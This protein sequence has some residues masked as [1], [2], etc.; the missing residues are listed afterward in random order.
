CMVGTVPT[1]TETRGSVMTKDT[2]APRSAALG[3]GRTER[4]GDA[5]SADAVAAS[6]YTTSAS[7]S[8]CSRCAFPGPHRVGPGAGPH[9][10]RLVCRQCGHFL[11]WLPKPRPV[12][13]EGAYDR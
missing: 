10:A 6:Y 2:T 8:A 12:V 1:R 5:G 13:Q 3:A 4:A 11:R 7:Q 9:H